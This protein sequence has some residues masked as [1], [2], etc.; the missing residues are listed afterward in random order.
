LWWSTFDAS[1]A[2]VATASFDEVIAT[3]SPPVASPATRSDLAYIL[4]TSGSTGV[5]KGVMLSHEN[6]LSFVDWCSSVFDPTEEDRFSSHA[7]F[8]FD[9]SVLDIYVAIKHGATLYLVSEELGK[10]PR[11]LAR[12][13]AAII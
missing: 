6:A 1:A 8:H 9:L 5:P 3:A 2:P 7:P 10:N 12:F 11:E 4:Y 13:I